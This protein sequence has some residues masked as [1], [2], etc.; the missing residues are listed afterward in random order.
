MTILLEVYES[1]MSM[2]VNVE[3]AFHHNE[4]GDLIVTC[5]LRPWK[6]TGENQKMMIGGGRTLDEALCFAVEAW[7][8]G[9]YLPLDWSA[10]AQRIGACE[11]L[12][13]RPTGEFDTK[14]AREALKARFRSN[15]SSDTTSPDNMSPQP[16]QLHLPEM[17]T[18][19]RRAK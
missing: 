19:N 14:R 4:E 5:R 8:D 3:F 12:P 1:V 13:V 9:Y 17:S 2:R 6:N 11:E 7:L 15:G 16:V 10:R 18:K